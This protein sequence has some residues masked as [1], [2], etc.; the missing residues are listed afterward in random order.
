MKAF[1]RG[2]QNDSGHCYKFYEQVVANEDEDEPQYFLR[3]ILLK[4]CMKLKKGE[5]ITTK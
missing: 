3:A 2:V 5:S 1:L 4:F